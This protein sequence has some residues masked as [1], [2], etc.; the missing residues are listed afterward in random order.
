M[1]R[2]LEKLL[3]KKNIKIWN[4]DKIQKKEEVHCKKKQGEVDFLLCPNLY[5]F[6][7]AHS[8]LRIRGEGGSSKKTLSE[9]W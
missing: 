7:Q 8:L 3:D 9:F 6:T 5:L 1:F 2:V 4:W